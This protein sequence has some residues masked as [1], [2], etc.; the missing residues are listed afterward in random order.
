MK[1][2]N[3]KGFTLIELLA[4]IVILGVI[5]LIAIPSVSSIIASSRK[6]TYKSTAETLISGARNM[7]LSTSTGDPGDGWSEVTSN[8][9]VQINKKASGV[10]YS[11]AYVI[12]VNVIKVEQGSNTKSPYGNLVSDYSFVVAAKN[13][14]GS[15]TYYIQLL[16]DSNYAIVYTSEETL[17]G[18]TGEVNQVKSDE[19]KEMLNIAGGS[20]KNDYTII[21][22]TV[23]EPESS[24]SK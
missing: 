17:S 7:V 14:D 20:N 11:K 3:K 4:V 1:N 5:M 19:K 23:A 10:T 8:G 6:N 18:G 16:D 12:P 22:V 13:T 15:Y 2:L 21:D 24:S 9:L